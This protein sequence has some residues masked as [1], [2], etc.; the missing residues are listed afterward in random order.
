VRINLP[1]QQITDV[2]K[3][4]GKAIDT[5]GDCEKKPGPHV[6]IG[7]IRYPGGRKG[8]LIYIKSSLTGDENDYVF[9]YKKRYGAFPHETTLDQLFSE[10][11]F[12]AYRALGFHATHRFF[13]RR[14]RFAH[15]DS[16]DNPSVKG[17]IA[18]LDALFQPLAPDLSW[19]QQHTTF[20]DWL[21]ADEKAEAEQAAAKSA[22][23]SLL[24]DVAAPQQKSRRPRRRLRRE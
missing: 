21:T 2:S 6:A 12:E 13:G 4:T 15:L 16:K 17:D 19:P 1:W 20:A 11:Q 10:E 22:E 8:I 3:A 23:K 7:E 18:F 5:E 9:H 24:A 14:D